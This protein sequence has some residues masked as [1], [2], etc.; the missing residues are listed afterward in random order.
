M[1]HKRLHSVFSEWIKL[2]SLFSEQIKLSSLF[3]EQ[4]KLS[5]LLSDQ[6]SSTEKNIFQW[7]NLNPLHFSSVN[8]PLDVEPGKHKG[9]AREKVSAY[10]GIGTS[11]CT[12]IGIGISTSWH[13]RLFVNT[14]VLANISANRGTHV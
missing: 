13:N 1:K 11:I 2:S 10:I 14:Y 9:R 6:T 5:S 8:E 7:L 3:S 12:F 4:I